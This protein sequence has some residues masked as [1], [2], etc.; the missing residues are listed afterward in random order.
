MQLSVIYTSF[1]VIGYKALHG[2][3][4]RYI[5]HDRK[6]MDVTRILSSS[7]K[8]LSQRAQPQSSAKELSQR[9]QP[10]IS[11]KGLSQ[12]VQPKRSAKALE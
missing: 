2:V 6:N 11:A 4:W 1:A 10:K 5:L 3:T 9:A 12:R 8:E 7:A